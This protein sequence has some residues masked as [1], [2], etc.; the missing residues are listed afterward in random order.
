M[1]DLFLREVGTIRLRV[2]TISTIMKTSASLTVPEASGAE[3][4]SDTGNGAIVRNRTLALAP[5]GKVTPIQK[6]SP[7][8]LKEY[9]YV[10]II[11]WRNNS[12]VREGAGS[13]LMTSF[14]AEDSLTLMKT[15]QHLKIFNTS[16]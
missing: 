3:T 4:G 7:N 12:R 2:D 8:P 9:L 14:A 16:Q 13:L 15:Q 6:R 1:A 11:T 5:F 10:E